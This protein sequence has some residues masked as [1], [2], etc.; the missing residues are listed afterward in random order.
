MQVCS[1]CHSPDIVATQRHTADGWHNVI[2]TMLG[3]GAVATD[4]QLDQIE[5][6][7]TNAFPPDAK[8]TPAAPSTKE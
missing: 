3:R 7:L 6:Y 2:A 5:N 1:Q 8:A 4:D